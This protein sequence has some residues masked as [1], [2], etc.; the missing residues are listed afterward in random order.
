VAAAMVYAGATLLLRWQGKRTAEQE[1]TRQEGEAARQVLNQLGGGELKILTFYANP[2]VIRRG[3]KG[4][5]CYGVAAAT[6]VSLEPPV[7]DIHPSLSRCVEVK[8][9]AST[10]Y[11]LRATD[12]K[13]KVETREAEVDVR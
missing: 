8:P 5:L 11:K 10:K 7:E 6:S 12:A 3:G 4:S 13:G 9:M 2:P 1:A